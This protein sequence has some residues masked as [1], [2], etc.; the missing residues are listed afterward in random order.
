MAEA[1]FRVDFPH[2]LLALHGRSRPAN[3]ITG[4]DQL[5][6]NMIREDRCDDASVCSRAT[7]PRS[8]RR[9]KRSPNGS[10]F[11]CLRFGPKAAELLSEKKS[12]RPDG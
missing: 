7:P 1:A 10:R 11:H 2:E 8:R 9:E 3:A 12:A 6:D 4:L 5:V